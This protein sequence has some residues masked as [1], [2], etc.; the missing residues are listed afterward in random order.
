MPYSGDVSVE[1]PAGTRP[2]SVNPG[3][4][5]PVDELVGRGSLITELLALAAPPSHGA[6]LLGDRRIGKTSLLRA[7]ETPLR[8]AGHLVVRVSAETSSLETFGRALLAGLRSDRRQRSWE[9][10]LEGE[11]QV[12]AG[13]G[14]I[15]LRG[16]GRRRN[17]TAEVD[18][19][20]A[21]ATAARSSGEGMR[22]ILLLDE[23]TVLASELDPAE[24][25]E[26]LH[27][28]RRARQELPELAMFLAGSIGLH[29]ALPG[30]KT[31]VND[32]TE[33]H[34]DVLAQA[35]AQLLAAGLLQ[36]AGIRTAEP[37]EVVAAMVEQTSGFPY[38]LHGVA[39]LLADRSAPVTAQSVREVVADAL[40]QDL[41]N[42]SHYDARL[43]SYYGRDAAES[44]RAILDTVASTHAPTS[45]DAL[46]QS[47]PVAAQGL[48]RTDLLRLLRRLEADHYLRRAGNDSA[49]A[50]DLVRRIWLHLRR[51]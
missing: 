20:S 49:F 47:P 36:G 4:I 51:L 37:G 18:L 15:V 12:S 30:D 6:L 42:T 27:T 8:E 39:Q 38:Y 9:V 7:I 31:G 43:E 45:P 16:K 28:L 14:R 25:R 50:S 5:V 35:D 24:G 19:F 21:C 11:V 22:V 34:V 10:D 46:L 48:S 29:H 33:I 3:G 32:L 41:W 13:P 1:W 23:F 2:L 26:F 44:V 40:E 17:E